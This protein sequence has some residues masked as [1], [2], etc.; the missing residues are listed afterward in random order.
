VAK[1]APESRYD[2]KELLLINAV[3]AHIA[4][5][6]GYGTQWGADHRRFGSDVA[7]DINEGDL[8]PV[9]HKGKAPLHESLIEYGVTG[10]HCDRQWGKEAYQALPRLGT[11]PANIGGIDAVSGMRPHLWQTLC[12][13]ALQN[14]AAWDWVRP[15]IQAKLSTCSPVAIDHARRNRIGRMVSV[16]NVGIAVG[17]RNRYAAQYWQ[18]DALLHDWLYRAAVA[19]RGTAP[20]EID[21]LIDWV[22]TEHCD[23][24]IEVLKKIRVRKKA[25]PAIA[26]VTRFDDY[27]GTPDELDELSRRLLN[28]E[29]VRSEDDGRVIAS[30]RA[31]HVTPW[32]RARQVKTQFKGNY[33][34]NTVIGNS[35]ES[36]RR[37]YNSGQGKHSD[38]YGSPKY[39]A[40]RKSR[41]SL[42]ERRTLAANGAYDRPDALLGPWRSCAGIN[43]PRVPSLVKGS[44]FSKESPGN[45]RARRRQRLRHF[46]NSKLEASTMKIEN[47][48]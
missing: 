18:A 41:L 46:H 23:T 39:N 42:A 24:G 9:R 32:F 31:L 12:A 7:D 33:N 4:N 20:E 44:N 29:S 10:K 22:Q 36:E 6:G 13:V 15:H 2:A 5:A 11:D 45:R 19:Y 40:L 16:E 1:L 34:L 43:I 25:G 8:L 38:W 21:R 48:L 27:P 30:L 37:Q 14:D 26:P 47:L 28:K 3:F 17:G 35:N